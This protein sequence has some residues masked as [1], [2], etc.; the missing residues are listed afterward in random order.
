MTKQEIQAKIQDKV[1]ALEVFVKQINIS[2]E[3]KQ[4]ITK[5]GFIENSI[6]YRDLEQY[7]EPAVEAPDEEEKKDVET[8]NI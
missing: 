4:V 7:P 8:T 1:K 2:I 3:A 6:F 5:D